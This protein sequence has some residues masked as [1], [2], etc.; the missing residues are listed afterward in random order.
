MC[1][2]IPAFTKS[3]PVLPFWGGEQSFPCFPFTL[4]QHQPSWVTLLSGLGRALTTS[5]SPCWWEL[6]RAVTLI[7]ETKPS[8]AKTKQPQQRGCQEGRAG[9]ASPRQYGDSRD[10]P[11]SKEEPLLHLPGEHLMQ[12]TQRAKT[13]LCWAVCS[14]RACREMGSVL[15]EQSNKL[16]PVN[17]AQKLQSAAM[18]C[19]REAFS[20]PASTS[21]A[22]CMLYMKSDG[23][24]FSQPFRASASCHRIPRG[25]ELQA[26]RKDPVHVEKN[27]SR[28]CKKWR[29]QSCFYLL[30]VFISPGSRKNTEVDCGIIENPELEE[31]I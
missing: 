31:L 24:C 17:S 29:E 3:H 9:S 4:H 28:Y 14:S 21:D 6:P 2:K 18:A 27:I 30:S 1:R 10:P 20:D 25:K 15:E 7:W 11:K 12:H 13:L 16:Q 5:L 19:L 22:F 8:T 23:T 26:R